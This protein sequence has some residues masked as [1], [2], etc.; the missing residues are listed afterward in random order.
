MMRVCA[1]AWSIFFQ[2]KC[3]YEKQRPYK[4]DMALQWTYYK[5]CVFVRLYVYVCVCVTQ[6]RCVF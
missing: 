3:A 2:C 1:R 6:C 4:G 5:R